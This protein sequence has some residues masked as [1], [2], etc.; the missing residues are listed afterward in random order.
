MYYS[1]CA[2]LTVV[3]YDHHVDTVV[4]V[5]LFQAVHQRPQSPVHLLQGLDH[6][7][8]ST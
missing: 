3:G 5:P 7:V 2:C 6:L 1:V 8:N 4:E